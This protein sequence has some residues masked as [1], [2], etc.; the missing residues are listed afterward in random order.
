ML[1][2][3]AMVM[4]AFLFL[5]LMCVAQKAIANDSIS[6]YLF[7]LDDCIIC[8]DYTPV[9]N[10]LYDTY[11]D[12]VQF[13]GYFP[14]FSSKQEKID[15]F[16]STYSVQFPLR[17]DYYKSVCSRYEATITPEAVVYNH[18]TETLLYKGRIDNK[19]V[20][21][22]RR[23]HVTTAHELSDVLAQIKAGLQPNI[24]NTQA[25]GCYINYSDAISKYTIKN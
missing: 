5:V 11:K 4:R 17:T 10:D 13:V 22:G 2:F 20:K 12:E 15:Q 18:T 25:V 6:V 3:G 16:A 24:Q 23:R 9:I 21:L 7:L 14:N 1:I 19:F 8:Q